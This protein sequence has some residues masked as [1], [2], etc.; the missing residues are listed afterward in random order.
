MIMFSLFLQFALEWRRLV[1]KL[2]KQTTKNEDYCSLSRPREP[3][4]EFAACQCSH[5]EC[6][7]VPCVLALY[8]WWFSFLDGQFSTLKVDSTKNTWCLSTP[9]PLP[10]PSPWKLLRYVILA[11]LVLA[12]LKSSFVLSKVIC[13]GGGSDGTE[14][15]GYGPAEYMGPH[16]MC[17]KR[18]HHYSFKHGKNCWECPQGLRRSIRGINSEYA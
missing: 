5:G 8:V 6:Q 15:C 12:N 18:Y 10:A 9:S 4:G 17:K 11:F 7:R 13:G 14:K 2:P 3:G 1:E 16:D